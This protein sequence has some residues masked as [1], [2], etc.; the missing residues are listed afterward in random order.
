[1]PNKR[2]AMLVFA[3]L[4]WAAFCFR[5]AVAR[6]LPND[7]PFD[8]QVYAQIA[9]NVLEQHVYSPAT[10]A[11]YDPSLIRLPGY[12][13]FL[14]GIYSVFGHG[15]NTAVRVAQAL[16][17]TAS[18]GL[19]ALIAFFWEPDDRLKRRTSI[20]ALVLAVLCP[21]TTIY[22]AT[23][24]TETPTVFFALA[25]CLTATLAFKSATQ[26]K[27]LLLWG[28]TGLLAGAAVLFRPDSGLFAAAIGITLVVT[29]LLRPSGVESSKRRPELLYRF[30]RASYLGAVFSLAFC[31]ALA[32][33]TIR[34]FRMFHLFQPLAPAHAEMPGEFVPRGYL[35]WLRTWIDDARYIDPVLWSL[36]ER[37]IQLETIPDKAF[38]SAEEKQRVAALLEKYNHP[39][40][41]PAAA[42]APPDSEPSPP[43]SEDQSNQSQESESSKTED[44]SAQDKGSDEADQDDQSDQSDEN[45]PADQAVDQPV[46][47]TPGIDAGFAQLASE[48]IRR[49]PLR[50]YLWLPTKRAASLWFDTHSQYYPFEGQLLPLE[51][52]DYDIHQ[53][54]WLPLFAGLTFLYT[55][56]GIAGGWFLWQT[57]D[58][59]AR[60]WLL[61]AALMI[62][63]RLAFFSSLENPE[64][65]YV[66]EIFPFLAIFGGIA[67]VRMGG[68][69]K[70]RDVS[71]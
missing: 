49:H 58:F 61:L 9:R 3:L 50:Y 24:L 34:N 56:L 5:V 54:F 14:S 46:E 42:N 26:K 29:T 1:M 13:L 30:S 17:D 66:V 68:L 67:L 32:P 59:I 4:L 63:L 44:E 70:G 47:M 21:F 37:P 8:G 60:Q 31:L 57:R 71:A 45:A 2:K 16:I 38:D 25:M 22:V 40:E 27:A 39:P 35:S 62:F 69:P 19:I 41:E 15:N 36:D 53:Q 11:P 28:A 52:L 23:I 10:E 51:D 12:P 20:A 7:A 55:L 43:L 33:W 18:C 64:P 48:R 6:F 65:R